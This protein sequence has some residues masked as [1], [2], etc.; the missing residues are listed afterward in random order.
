MEC[1]PMFGY[2]RHGAE[3][4]LR[5]RGLQRGGLRVRRAEEP[6]AAGHRPADG[7]RG[8]RGAGAHHAAR[9]RDRVRVAVLVR[10][11]ASPHL[12]GGLRPHGAH[13][14]LL[15]RV[16]QP[17]RLPRPP[18]ARLPAAQ[19]R[20]PSRACPTRPP[21]PCWPRPPRRCPRRPHGERNWDYRYSWIRD[22]TFMLWGLYTLGFDWEAND[23]FYFVADAGRG[24]GGQ[25]QIMYGVGGEKELD[26]ETLDHLSGYEGARPVRDRQRR[27]EPEPARRVGRGARLRLPAHALARPPAGARVAHPQEAGGARHRQ[28]ARPGPRHLGGARRAQALHLVEAH[29]LGGAR[30]RRAAGAHA[31]RPGVRGPWQAEADEIH[32]DIC[33]NGLDE[34]NVFIQHYDTTRSTPR[35]C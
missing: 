14:R 10:A 17:R 4:E 24:R 32:A 12:R 8:P 19:R 26:E 2:G 15:A 34:R 23:F 3:W 5:G 16:A 21:A 6:A 11:R 25:L 20:S 31:R 7:L 35:C 13:G 27:V 9:G 18:V 30:P 28:L 22:T 1:E 29:V 33:E